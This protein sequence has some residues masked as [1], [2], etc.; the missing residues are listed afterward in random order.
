MSSSES[1]FSS[2][3]SSSTG[4]TS[5]GEGPG[6]PVRK[7]TKL[8]AGGGMFRSSWDLPP[9]IAESTKGEK[10][11]FCKL[12][13]S[14][15]SVSHGGFNDITHHMNCLAHVQ[16]AGAGETTGFYDYF[17]DGRAAEQPC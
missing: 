15:F 12:C 14:H 13:N 9:Y 3:C 6:S 16:T 4:T 8:V 2:G 17:L 11:A 10:F 5:S 1:S 7:K